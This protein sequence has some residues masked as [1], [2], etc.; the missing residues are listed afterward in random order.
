M[1]AREQRKRASLTDITDIELKYNN[2]L[3]SVWAFGN[4]RDGEKE[5]DRDRETKRKRER[6]GRLN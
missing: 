2:S 1:S 4:R 6:L 3:L 5:T